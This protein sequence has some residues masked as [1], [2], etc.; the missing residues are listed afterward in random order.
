[1]S[2]VI[3]SACW[4]LEGMSI[5]QKAVLISLADNAN[6]YGVCWPSIPT[7]ARRVCGSE[8]AVQNA[9]RWLEQAGAVTADRSNGRHTSYMITP[10]TY[11]PPSDSTPAARA[12]VKTASNASNPRGSCGGE[13]ADSDKTPAAR[14]GVEPEASEEPPQ[15]VRGCAD[16]DSQNQ[17]MA[18]AGESGAPV[19]G[20]HP[21]PAPE[22]ADPRTACTQPPHG[23]PSNRQEPPREPTR[24][25]TGGNRLAEITKDAVAAYNARLAKPAGQLPAV[26]LVNE[27]RAKQVK[28]CLGVAAAIC[29]QMYGSPAIT[30][31]FW[32]EYFRHCSL[33]PWLSGQKQ[34]GKGHENYV[35]DFELMTRADKMTAVFDKAMSE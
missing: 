16:G 17:R 21:T 27:V 31:E 3:M 11:R 15:L 29:Q 7:I 10:E 33:D 25:V 12:G 14:A 19:H 20:V 32:D 35:P 18:C 34:G 28:R 4:P 5:P 8:R 1:M 6:D 9:I 30:R 26:H 24:T 13:G 2:T 22:S 23:V